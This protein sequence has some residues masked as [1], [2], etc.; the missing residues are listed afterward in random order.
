MKAWSALLLVLLWLLADGPAQAATYTFP[1]GLP[2]GCS[3]SAG[4]Y[5][6]P[7]GFALGYGDVVVI[8]SP[9]PAR[10]TVTGN[11]STNNVVFNNAGSASDVVVIVQ[12]TLTLG[13]QAVLKAHIVANAINGTDASEVQVTGS[14]TALTGAL[15]LG[16]RTQVTGDVHTVTGNISTGTEVVITGHISS[17]T[18][19]VNLAYKDQVGG[20]ITT[21]GAVSTGTEV[22][23]NGPLNGASGNVSVDYASHVQAV[24]TTSGTLTLGGTVQAAACLR[25]TQ[26]A[27]ITLGYGASVNSVCCGA[28]C[29][30]ACVSKSNDDPLPATCSP[31]IVHVGSSGGHNASTGSD[32]LTINKP[33]SVAAGDVMLAW[34]SQRTD[35]LPLSQQMAAVPS[36]W[37]V[38][39]TRDNGNNFGTT[40]Y[41]KV[42]GSSEPGSYSW[43]FHDNGRAAGQIIAFR[44][45]DTSNPINSSASQLNAA[46]TGYTAPAVTTT[47]ANSM[48][49]AL[50]AVPVG[51]SAMAAP[52]GSPVWSGAPAAMSTGGSGGISTAAAFVLQATAGSSGN[53]VSSG[54]PSRQSVGALLALRASTPPLALPLY[55]RAAEVPGGRLSTDASTATA[56]ANHDPGRDSAAGLLLAKG[57]MGAAETNTTKYQRWLSATGG[58]TLSGTVELHIWSAMKDFNSSKGGRLNAYL[59]SCS[60]AGTDCQSFASSSLTAGPWSD[61]SSTWVQKTL[62]FG[63]LNT[64]LAN[65]RVLELKIVVHDSSD[66]DM[67]LAYDSTGQASVLQVA[68]SAAVD[69]YE[70]SLPSTSLS[71]LP[72]TVTVTACSSSSAPC[73]SPATTLAG[74]TAT[75]ATSAGTLGSTALTFDAN[76]VASTTL[77]HPTAANGAS[78]SVTLSAESVAATN[79]RRCCP[80]G[81]S[82]STA[83]SCATS[84]STA[85][86]VIAASN[87]GAATTVAAQTAGTASASHVLRA[88]RSG[89]NTAA[90]E[91][92]L[93]GA[94]NVD[95]GYQCNN[96]ASCHAANLMSLNGGSPTPIARNNDGVTS[97]STAVAMVFD[98]NGNAPFSFTHADVGLVTL[99][100]SKAV[101]GATLV[102]TS[103]AF[104][105]KPA[106]FA[107]DN[108]RQTAAPQRNNPAAND[109]SG[110]L[111]VAAGEAFGLSITAQTSTDATAPSFGRESPAEG[112]L[113]SPALVLPSG[114]VAGTLNNA[115]VAGGSFSAGVAT[116]NNLAYSEV[117]IVMLTPAVADGNYLG[118]GAVSGTASGNVGRFVPARFALSGGSVTHRSS[119]VCSP[120]SGFSYLGE[121]FRLAFT[122]TAQNSSGATTQNYSGSFAKLDA[123]SAGSWALAGL[124]GSTP[125]STGSGRLA[126]GTASG[127]W[128]AGV[129]SNISLVAQATRA[130]SPDGPFNSAAFGIAPVDSDGVALAS[131]DMASTAGGAN[132]R[133][134]VATVP[135]VFGR[136]RL[137]SA[138]GAADRALALPATL[139]R[140]GGSSYET[141][142]DD[143]CTTV[144]VGAVSFGNLRRSLSTADTAASGPIV[145]SAGRGTL[146][147]AAPGGGRSGTVDVA[148]SLGSSAT[149]ASC[150]QPWAPGSGDAATAGANL[151]HL[152]SAWC[153][154]SHDKDPAARASFGLPRGA[155]TWVYRREN[156]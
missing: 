102:G 127:S 6:C 52:G 125:F 5:T 115:T 58:I 97:G 40:L 140:W 54:N 33:A 42:A 130:S 35:D 26:S 73:T 15:S 23:I 75:L 111:F 68:A 104:V 143:S 117:G 77:S 60:A 66:D 146:R 128:A 74:A 118:A 51:D 24:T 129:A 135:L 142:S 144:P 112:V 90:C 114:G 84:F 139:Q 41:R 155:N 22:V 76:G 108:I 80:P 57:G 110:A 61:G 32:V 31:G 16:Y 47:A 153:G 34:I 79:A 95:W 20:S 18:G 3:G 86:F 141:H 138:T 4:E 8:N 7:G 99:R 56:Q 149:D 59:R 156:Y 100:A 50:Y 1:G 9:K 150:L 78:V 65:D 107:L 21:A 70:L 43:E 94:Q 72:S 134:R 14:L 131:F 71:C 13:Y 120:A 109:A 39:L 116:V 106:R 154:S 27:S 25:S 64:T 53:K 121:N 11:L 44:G 36:G 152:R 145:F 28:T 105:V 17:N 124:G 29:G 69:H 48:L 49:V 19:V 30:T 148:L 123:A 136:L 133:A 45:V 98:S 113:L 93:T 88:V 89:S 55:L 2:P 83:D 81:G 151:A 87:G 137:D 92:A 63:L 10:I 103:N 126:L 82:C 101:N 91:A 62:S 147:L 96:P 46:S 119:L 67:W 37:T 38:V 85:G 12:G 122:L 132:D